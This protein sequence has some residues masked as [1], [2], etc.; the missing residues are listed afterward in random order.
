[1]R[2]EI[3]YTKIEK[4]AIN[5]G[6]AEIENLCLRASLNRKLEE[7]F[8]T[9]N[10]TLSVCLTFAKTYRKVQR[11]FNIID[12]RSHTLI[13]RYTSHYIDYYLVKQ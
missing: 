10:I 4:E 6:F 13:Y 8:K 2:K 12:L 3:E 9:A 11:N 7:A 5:K 1:M